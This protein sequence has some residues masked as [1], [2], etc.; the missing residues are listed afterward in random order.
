MCWC[1]FPALA[2]IAAA[3][4]DPLE[5]QRRALQRI[6]AVVDH[7]RKTG[8]LASRLPDLTQAEA[9]LAKSNQMLA[10]RGD[11]LPLALGLIKQGHCYR[12]QGQWDRSIPFYDLAEKAAL[13][14]GTRHGRPRPSRGRPTSETSR[15]NLGQAAADARQAVQLAEK[16]ADNDLLAHA[17][18][19]LGLVQVEQLDLAGA[20]DT[21]NRDVSVA[22][23]ARD[24]LKLYYAVSGR[25]EVYLKLAQRCDPKR[26]SETCQ[27]AFARARGDFEQAISIVR[28]R[29]FDGLVKAVQAQLEL[30]DIPVR[31][32]QLHEQVPDFQ[33]A[34]HPKTV[35]DVLITERF[36]RARLDVPP[37]LLAFHQENIG[38]LKKRGMRESAV[39]TQLINYIEGLLNEAAGKNDEALDFYLKT[40][41]AMESD[42]GA[43]RDDRA[44]GTVLEGRM[45]GYH[46]AVRLLL[47]HKR[48]ADAFHM[49]ERS[50]SRAL[51]D[52]LATRQPGLGR[53]LEQKLYA[54][55]A[56]LRTQIGDAQGRLFELANRAD[57]AVDATRIAQL[58]T[59]IRTLESQHD[60]VTARMAI[61]APRLQNLVTSTPAT[62]EALQQS[63]RDE[64]YELLQYLVTDTGLIVW[65]IAPGSVTVRNV[66]LP[67]NILVDKVASLQKSLA[68]RNAPFD[69]TTAQELFL[70]LIR[71]CCRWSRATG[72]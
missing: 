3:Q 49:F 25:A 72:W 64:R 27:Q 24:P 41:N 16:A 66:F 59:E 11:W 8:E 60:Q 43:L 12:L 46:S 37:N 5:L 48:Y 21:F 32:A 36:T 50:R 57:A 70:Y 39:A 51:S 54:E 10:A 71:R 6:D 28:S 23:K 33:A 4:E 47:V 13:R 56:V 20:S 58:D 22:Q 68:D 34:F 38:W 15:R 19:V 52:L 17:L 69:E 14:G 18:E 45:D 42:R 1:L 67:R 2:Q 35:S 40:V 44:R 61:E 31:A 53:P 62:L 63:M 55:S 29:Q 7:A 30:M 26:A 65:H 9:E